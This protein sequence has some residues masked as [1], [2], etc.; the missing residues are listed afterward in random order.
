MGEWVTTTGL[1]P[2]HRA[3]CGP[4]CVAYRH[5]QGNRVPSPTYPG[6]RI[7]MRNELDRRN[8]RKSTDENADENQCKDPL[9]RLT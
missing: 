6:L 4:R 7:E 8:D 9:R 3:C 2:G 5:T 1:G